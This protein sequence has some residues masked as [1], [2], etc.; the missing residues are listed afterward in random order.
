MK[1]SSDQSRKNHKSICHQA[2]GYQTENRQI[3]SCPI[4]SYQSLYKMR[5]ALF[6]ITFQ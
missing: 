5:G 6:S 4:S 1:I 3:I 2:V